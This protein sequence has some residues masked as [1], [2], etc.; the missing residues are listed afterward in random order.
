[1]ERA[2][3]GVLVYKV[4]KFLNLRWKHALIFKIIF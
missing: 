2:Q 4:K 3:L 1:M